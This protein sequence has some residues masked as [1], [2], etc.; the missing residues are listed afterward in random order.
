MISNKL[1][2]V[3]SKDGLR[4]L[5]TSFKYFQNSSFLYSTNTSLDTNET[6]NKSR[7]NTIKVEPINQNETIKKVINP[8]KHEDFFELNNLVSLEELFK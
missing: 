5:N 4:K 8:L 2:E 3:I 7:I 6:S 1:F